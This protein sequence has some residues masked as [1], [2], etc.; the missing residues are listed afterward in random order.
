MTVKQ[1]MEVLVECNPNA[2][3]C[4]EA[5]EEPEAKMIG[6]YILDGEPYV[7]IGDDLET[8]EYELGLK[9]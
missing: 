5:F 3:I 9:E 2:T 7:Y 6:E 4:V 8:L 1:L